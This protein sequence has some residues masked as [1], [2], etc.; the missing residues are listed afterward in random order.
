LINCN[1]HV[2]LLQ[3][4]YCVLSATLVIGLIYRFMIVASTVEKFRSTYFEEFVDVS[5]VE[6]W[7]KVSLLI[8]LC[9]S[10]AYCV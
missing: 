3:L 6:C 1:Y 7:D 5:G 9:S 8:V 4:S 2:V 10:D